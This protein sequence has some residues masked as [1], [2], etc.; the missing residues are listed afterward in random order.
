MNSFN[1]YLYRAIGEWLHNY[2]ADR[3]LDKE[4]PGYKHILFLPH[5]GGDM[6]HAKFD[7]ESRYGLI[8]S[9]WIVK[10]ERFICEVVIPSIVSGR[11]TLPDAKGEDV[12]LNSEP[13]TSGYESFDN[14]SI[15]TLGSGNYIFEY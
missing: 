2:V 14:K 5:L 3:R 9:A 1:H 12:I 7:F 10:D 13:Q 15:I 8:R 4:I 6:I 11:I